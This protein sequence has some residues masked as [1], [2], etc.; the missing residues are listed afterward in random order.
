MFK[1]TIDN[2]SC[3]HLIVKKCLYFEYFKVNNAL[4]LMKIACKWDLVS[5]T[6]GI[7]PKK[8]K[9]SFERPVTLGLDNKECEFNFD[10]LKE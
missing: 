5:W 6:Q 2:K 7:I 1:R 4:E 9:F 10:R 3:Y 8:H